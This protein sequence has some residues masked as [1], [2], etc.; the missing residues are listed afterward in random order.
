MI[1]LWQAQ[2]M[3]GMNLNLDKGALCPPGLLSP[4]KIQNKI[5]VNTEERIRFNQIVTFKVNSNS[6][7]QGCESFLFTRPTRSLRICVQNRGKTR[8]VEHILIAFSDGVYP[9]TAVKDTDQ[10]QV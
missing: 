7:A 2:Q 3:L 5:W 8:F 1:S 10:N 6:N 4:W 9:T